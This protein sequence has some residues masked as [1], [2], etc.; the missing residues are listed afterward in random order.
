MDSYIRFM[1]PVIP[2]TANNLLRVIDQKIASG[3]QRIHLMISSPGGSV[4]HGLSIH[5]YLK[6]APVEVITYNFGSVDSIGVVMFCAGDRRLC[7]PN[8]RF[9]IH[10]VSMQ[11]GANITLEEKGLDEKLKALKIDY[12]NIANVIAE[13][14]GK[15]K[16]TVMRNMNSR[17]TLNPQEALR[18]GL[19]HEIRASLFPAGADIS[20]VYEDGQQVIQGHPVFMQ[21]GIPGGIVHHITLPTA[22]GVTF[23]PSLMHVT[24]SRL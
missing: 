16:N 20:F 6:G 4:F 14:C 3:A 10:G 11:F 1:A 19:V 17:T 18:Y 9:L 23:N 21:P 15:S 2:Q 24:E 13:T 7:V 8:A 12:Q 5:N 22:H